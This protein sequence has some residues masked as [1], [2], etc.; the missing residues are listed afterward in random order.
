[1]L[2]LFSLFDHILH[3]AFSVDHFPFAAGNSVESVRKPQ[4][5]NETSGLCLCLCC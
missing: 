2:T 3:I 1:M 5:R 4:T